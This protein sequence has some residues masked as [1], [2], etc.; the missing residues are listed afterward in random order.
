MHI[1]LI[2]RE[3]RVS[4]GLLLSSAPGRMRVMLRGLA[5]ALEFRQVDGTWM[6]ES[7][8]AVEI[9]AT[10]PAENWRDVENARGAARRRLGIAADVLGHLRAN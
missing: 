2:Y 6:S 9:A 1:L 4:E 7:G 5:D 10:M 8:A 3:G